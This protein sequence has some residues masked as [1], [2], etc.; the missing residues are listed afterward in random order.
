[1][2]ASCGHTLPFEDTGFSLF[3]R[4]W[5]GLSPTSTAAATRSQHH[6]GTKTRLDDRG[7][8]P[9][10]TRRAAS[11]WANDDVEFNLVARGLFAANTRRAAKNAV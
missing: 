10:P 11:R 2:P 3:A 9:G 4:T 8:V 5:K 6:D 1:M 7:G